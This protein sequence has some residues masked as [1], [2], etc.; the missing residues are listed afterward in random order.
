MERLRD[1]EERLAFE[2]EGVDCDNG[3]EFL[4]HQVLRYL[5]QRPAPVE[6]TR[7]RPYRKN[8]P[9]GSAVLCTPTW[10]KSSGC[11]Y[12]NCWDTTGWWIGGW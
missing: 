8:A 3:S 5:R 2:V 12:G 1:I 11:M 4:N 10:S 7:S 9:D 6:F